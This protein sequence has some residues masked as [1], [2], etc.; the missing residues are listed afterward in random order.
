MLGKGC[1]IAVLRIDRNRCG[2]AWHGHD[3]SETVLI[4]LFPT[5]QVPVGYYSNTVLE[6]G[7]DSVYNFKLG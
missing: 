3:E 7:N 5:T 1:G 6:V 4:D 2:T